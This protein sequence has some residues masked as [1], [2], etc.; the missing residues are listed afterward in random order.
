MSYDRL[1]KFSTKRPTFDELV[2]ISTNFLGGIGTVETEENW[3]Y[4][5]LPGTPTHPLKGLPN[6]PE[7]L[8]HPDYFRKERWIEIFYNSKGDADVLT[9]QQDA[10]TTGLANQLAEVIRLWWQG[11]L[12]A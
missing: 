7:I 9:R 8:Q 10:F 3:I 6:A 12:E 5:V 1:I 11:T 2:Q 4:L